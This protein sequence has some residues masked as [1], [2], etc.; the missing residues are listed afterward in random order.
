MQRAV[1]DR[2]QVVVAGDVAVP[3]QVVWVLHIVG[4]L[5]LGFVEQG[6]RR[7]CEKIKP[8]LLL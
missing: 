1:S 6:E 8:T 4:D 3:W 5:M 7:L 2:E